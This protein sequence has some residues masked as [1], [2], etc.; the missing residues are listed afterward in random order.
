M[1]CKKL[2]SPLNIT[3]TLIIVAVVL[4]FLM[5]YGKERMATLL[6]RQSR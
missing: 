5:P 6:T 4:L 2:L 1:T 3:V